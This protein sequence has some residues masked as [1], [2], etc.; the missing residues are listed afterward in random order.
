VR[1][2]SHVCITGLTVVG[3]RAEIYPFVALGTTPQSTGYRGEPTRLVIGNDCQFREGVTISI[4]T[5]QGGGVTTVG[6]RCFMMANS[7]VAHDCTVGNDVT[8]ANNAVLGGHVTVGDHVFLGGQAAIHQF[9]QIG[10]GVMI[11]GV[12][13]VTADVIPYGF[14]KGQI[15]DLAGLNV[16]GLRR[17]GVAHADI[18]RIRRAY[19]ALFLGAGTFADRTKSVEAE[20]EGDPHVGKILGFIRAKRSRPLMMAAADQDEPDDET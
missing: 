6:D 7:H 4:G 19:R 20:F 14:A 5:A 8:F 9:V 3:E 18:H 17:R 2:H 1:L 13:G 12:S 16:I 10:D 11:G 15:A